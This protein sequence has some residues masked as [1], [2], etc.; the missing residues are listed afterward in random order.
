MGVV[1]VK[2]GLKYMDRIL[3]VGAGFAGAVLA[4][5]LVEAFGCSVDVI[6][7]RGHIAGNCHT[8]R[9]GES[10]VM[11]HVY[12]P[13]IFNTSHEDVW[14]YVQ[15]YGEMVPY[16][17]AVK[18][19]TDKGVFSLP[20]NLHTINQFFERKMG[21][22]EAKEFILGLGAGE[23]FEA[24][25]FEEQAIGMLGE[26][27][28]ENFFKGYTIKQWGVSPVE[29]DASILKRLPVRFSYDDN[30]YSRKYQ[31]IPRH[32]Y[33]KIV[34]R[35]LDHAKINV[36]LG[37]EFDSSSANA[38]DHVFYSG[39]I[40]AYYGY[41]HGRLG[42][43]TI[44]FDKKVYPVG[45]F[46]GNAVINYCSLNEEHTRQHEHAHFCPWESHDK[47]LVLTE[48]SKETG[49]SDV[50]YYPKRLAADMKV[51]AKYELDAK[52][53]CGITFIGRL[54]CYRYLDMDQVI[55]ESL[56]LAQEVRAAVVEG[57]QLPFF[58]S[59]RGK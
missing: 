32:G 51:F 22:A 59:V 49:A 18:A 44:F 1:L 39:P 34:E 55:G 35:I 56:D 4:R 13:H 54:G 24:N 6:D 26:D 57:R 30:Y 36:N 16:R 12:G 47:T 58:A 2:N 42:Y 5:E 43:R 52:S 40:D 23:G 15:K 37:S 45:D 53:D 14:Q 27:L 17:N 31:G 3:I 38:Y 19:V 28:Y 29:L 11:E 8:E 10:G 21:P 48:Y 20:I 7:R 50:P 9:D 25:N 46:Q 33:T 41:K